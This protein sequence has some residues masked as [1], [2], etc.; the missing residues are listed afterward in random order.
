MLKI[1]DLEG[2][3]SIGVEVHKSPEPQSIQGKPNPKYIKKEYLKHYLYYQRYYS[4]RMS[5]LFNEQKNIVKKTI[6]ERLIKFC[7]CVYFDEL[8]DFM[9]ADF[10]LIQF[11]IKHKGIEVITVGDF[12]Q[13]SVSKSNKTA[14][15]PFKKG[16]TYI[17]KE[18]YKSLFP[19]STIIDETTLIKNRRVPKEICEF[20]KTKLQIH[21]ESISTVKGHFELVNDSEKIKEMLSDQSIHKLF[22]QESSKYACTPNINWGYSKGDTYKKTCIILTNTFN[23]LFDDDFS[24]MKLSSTQINT[25]YVA[26]T[27]ATHEVYFIK[28]TDFREFKNNFKKVGRLF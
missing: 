15:K 19:A 7:D 20:I 24:I 9:E 10:N 14:S 3:S 2:I 12:Y 23:G 25:L 18:D 27:R 28:E 1:G 6:L 5:S 16:K 21:I 8:Q 11:F 17:S 22:Y 26:I 13:H 4:S